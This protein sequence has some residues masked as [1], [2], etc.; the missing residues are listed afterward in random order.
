MK[1]KRPVND[2]ELHAYLDGQLDSKQQQEIENDLQHDLEASEKLSDYQHINRLLHERYDPVLHEPVPQRL[3]IRMK[4]RNNYRAIAASLLFFL[5]GTLVGWQAQLNLVSPHQTSSTD[6]DLIQPAAFAHTV[7]TSDGLRPVEVSA[8][9]HQQLDSW[10]SKRLK[11]SLS[12]PDLM[13]SGY[14]LIGGRLLPSTEDRMAAQYMYEDADGQR[15]T[16]YVRRGNW[17]PGLQAI[18]VSQQKGYS[19]FYWIEKDLGYAIT[20]QKQNANNR[21]LVEEVYRQVKQQSVKI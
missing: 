17:K 4:P 5:T 20:T 14:R 10:L 11:T 16:L 6:T 21:Q 2:S 15:L 1:D 18:N 19:M 13:A 8:A 3:L 9:E 12:A 7:Y